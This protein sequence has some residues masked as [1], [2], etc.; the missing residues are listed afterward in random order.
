M[1]LILIAILGCKTVLGQAPV[2][3][4]PGLAGSVLEGKFDRPSTPYW[5]CIRKEDWHVVFFSVWEAARPHCLVNELEIFYDNATGRYSN[6]PGVEIRAYDFGG[7]NG[8]VAYDP[9]QQWLTQ[10]FLDIAQDLQKD[11][12]YVVGKSLFGAPYDFRLA[13]EGLEQ[14]GYFEQLKELI[15]GAVKNQGFPATIISHSM[16]SKMLY[17]YCKI[18]RVQKL[19]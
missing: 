3:L 6:Q 10:T 2:V 8:V 9:D 4:V 14:V 13:S 1:I 12:G 17:F 11:G 15:E 18:K 5:D 19:Q 7:I 16:V